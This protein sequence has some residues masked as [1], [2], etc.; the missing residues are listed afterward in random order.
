M[1]K[2]DLTDVNAITTT[3]FGGICTL[4]ALPIDWIET[5]ATIS[6]FQ[7]VVDADIVPITGKDWIKLECVY[8]TLNFSDKSQLTAA[9]NFFTKKLIGHFNTDDIN[10]LTQMSAFPYK[11]FVIKYV[12]RNGEVK[13]VGRESNGLKFSVDFNTGIVHAEKQF[14][15]F[16]F[17]GEDS[18]LSPRYPVV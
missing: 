1:N 7:H 16:S 2:Y 9:G 14:Y 8:D 17:D 13:L 6:L 3:N 10:I 4:E 12:S 5:D 11:K 15:A 18:E